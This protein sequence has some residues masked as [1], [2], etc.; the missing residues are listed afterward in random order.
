M[1]K[2]ISWRN[3]VYRICETVRK[4]RRGHWGRTH[5]EELFEVDRSAAIGLMN[6]IG[7]GF[8]IDKKRFI[9]TEEVLRFVE[10]M[11]QA[12]DLGSEYAMWVAASANKPAPAEIETIPID[13]IPCRVEDLPAEIEIKV[14]ELRVRGGDYGKTLELVFRFIAAVEGDKRGVRARLDPPAPPA[15]ETD[16]MEDMFKRMRERNQLIR[17]ERGAATREG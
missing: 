9:P 3:Q 14:G 8:L 7:G 1:A 10:A 6:G 2:K 12:D 17:A 15:K 5:I 16:P 11:A 4:S 13:L